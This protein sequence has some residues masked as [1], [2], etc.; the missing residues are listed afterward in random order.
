M[1]SSYADTLGDSKKRT[2]ENAKEKRDD[3]IE[4]AAQAKRDIDEIKEKGRR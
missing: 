3:F 4:K 2:R 1:Q